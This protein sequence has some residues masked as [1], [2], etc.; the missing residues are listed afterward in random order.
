MWSKFNPKFYRTILFWLGVLS[1]VAE[2]YIWHFD[3]FSARM[4][5]LGTG[6]F[7]IVMSFVS[8]PQGK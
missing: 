5:G 4:L 1:I 2:I 3:S 8:K 7:L 6:L